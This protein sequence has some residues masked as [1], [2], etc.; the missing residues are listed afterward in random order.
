MKR[1]FICLLICFAVMRVS[2]QTV[3]TLEDC[4]GLAIS[5]NK[6]VEIARTTLKAANE[7]KKAALTQFLPNISANGTYA[8]NEKSISLLNEDKYLPVYATNSDG[9]LNFAGSVSNSW[10]VVNGT[11]VPLD[12]GGTPFDPAKNPEKILW[13]NY[14][15]LPKEAMEFDIQNVFAGTIGFTQPL[16]MG[17]K[18]RELYKL[19]RYGE[20]LAEVNQESKTV[21]LLMEVDEAY[22]RVISLQNKLELAEEYRN[23]LAK[24]DSDVDVM[25]EAG[26]ATKADALKVKVKLNEAD[27][28]VTKAENG[29]ALSRMALNQLCGI[30]LESETQLSDTDLKTGSELP[31]MIPVWQA[32]DNR[33][34]IKALSQMQNIARSNVKIMVSR[35]LPTVALTGGY[36]VSNPNVYNGY[37]NE[38]GGMFNVGVVAHIPIFHFGENIHTLNAAKYKQRIATMQLDE[39]KEKIQLQIE[40]NSYKVTESI[41]KRNST[42]KNIEKA[43]ENL[44]CATDGFE[45]GVITSTDLLSAQIAWL[46]AKSEDIDAAIDEKLSV[47]YLQKSMGTLAFPH[48]QAVIK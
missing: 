10:I 40:Q 11:Y 20:N 27:V 21:D 44:K 2:A 48:S 31:Q 42:R 46:A 12:A 5:H 38:F 30:P 17:G 8:W 47:T 37:A 24:M 33:P 45:E 41:K 25:I 9:S 3:L 18:I 39:A 28:M 36:L 23:L 22:W 34:E 43:Q 14:A 19:A 7:L 26:F 16:Y 32:I 35:F 1:T 4:R 6:T 15:L 13:K 29:V